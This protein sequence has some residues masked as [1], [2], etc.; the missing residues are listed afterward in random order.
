MKQNQNQIRLALLLVLLS[1]VFW[2]GMLAVPFVPLPLSAWQKGAF[3]LALFILAEIAFWVG[4]LLVGK[5]VILRY[6]KKLWPKSWVRRKDSLAV[7]P[8]GEAQDAGHPDPKP[9]QLSS[10]E[11][12]G[13]IEKYEGEKGVN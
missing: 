5:E 6:L 4:A 8:E 1:G 13:R 11:G 3:A 12:G 10:A 7:L 2:F 9:Q